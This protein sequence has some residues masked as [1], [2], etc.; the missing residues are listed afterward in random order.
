MD[1]PEAIRRDG[2]AVRDSDVSIFYYSLEA[3]KLTLEER[4][5]YA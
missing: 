1:T 5:Y 3:D 4:K 2:Y